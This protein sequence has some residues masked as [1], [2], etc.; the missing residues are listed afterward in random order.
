MKKFMG[1]NFLLQTKTAKMLYHEFAK[2]Q[3]SM[4]TTATL[5]KE[6]ATDNRFTTSPMHGLKATTTVRAM[7]SNRICEELI[8][9][10][11]ADP[12]II[13]AGLTP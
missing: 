4:T 8:T 12:S 13:Y 10:K 5:P 6:I 2:D 9:G 11:E 1:K 7:R 3:R